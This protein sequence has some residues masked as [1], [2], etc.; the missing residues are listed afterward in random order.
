[1]AIGILS[2]VFTNPDKYVSA[3]LFKSHIQWLP[4]DQCHLAFHF[5][6]LLTFIKTV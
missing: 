5:S 1:L 3:D 2:F 6:W 4:R